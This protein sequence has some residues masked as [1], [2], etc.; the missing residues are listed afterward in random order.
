MLTK[1]LD[2]MSRAGA[3]HHLILRK[4]TSADTGLHDFNDLKKTVANALFSSDE[5]FGPKFERKLKEKHEKDRQLSGLMPE[6]MFSDKRKQTFQYKP[7]YNRLSSTGNGY[8]GS[9]RKPSRRGS[10]S[11]QYNRGTSS[12]S[13]VGSVRF[14]GNKD[15]KA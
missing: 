13:T 4:V 9:C 3:F 8:S 7:Y 1:S 11:S 14:Q 5:I 15:S 10:Y 6:K 2:K 12:S